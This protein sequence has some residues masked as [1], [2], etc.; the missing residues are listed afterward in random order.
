M[1]CQLFGKYLVDKKAITCDEYQVAKERQLE[2]RVKLGTIAVAEGL[3]TED[4]AE[5]VNR[6]QL[7]QDRRFGDI[8]VEE[9]YLTQE[10]VRMMLE[11]QGSP[12]MQFMQALLESGG[13]SLSQMNDYITS[14]QKEK[15]FS[16]A[17]MT[18]L[19]NED[20]D[21]L[22]PLFAFSSKPF[23]TELAGL[24]VRNLIRFVSR[25]IYLGQMHHV[26]QLEYRYLV[27]QHVTG[28]Y[29]VYLAI[30]EEEGK[31]GFVALAS[32]FAKESF[33]E[34]CADVYDAVGEFIN[35]NNGLF[36]SEASNRGIHMELEPALT[37][38]NQV[39]EGKIYV[40]PVHIGN[41]QLQLLIAV[42]SRVT[43]GQTPCKLETEPL[44]CSLD[45]DDS[46]RTV[47]VIDDS[48]MSRKMLRAILE[49]EGYAVVAEA[50]DGEEGLKAYKQYHPAVVTMDIT[51]PGM[52]GI[53]ALR[54]IMEYD[55]DARVVMITAAGQQQKI[56]EALRLG[57]AR[58]ITKP[59]ERVEVAAMMKSML[60]S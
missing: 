53:A 28:D 32:S 15:G 40:L 19:K 30:A 39:V 16:D 33:Q 21:A 7:Q 23:V 42:D 37:Y 46:S 29:D 45:T 52:D 5:A 12:Y 4:L 20:M 14:F 36:A 13:I 55:R 44:E 47:L 22:V 34:T 59:F 50:T 3:M 6:L 18:A 11:R 49:E 58:F 31:G 54:E 9:G 41:V 38:E 48:K 17:D 2:A 60:K 51:M 1:F 10:Q 27:G 26:E 24:V 56:I 43:L 57:A 8:A 35:C 25:D